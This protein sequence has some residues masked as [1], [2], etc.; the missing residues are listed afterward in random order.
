MSDE[1]TEK[2]EASEPKR[3]R[4]ATPWKRP[5]VR[6]VPASR[7]EIHFGPGTDLTSGAS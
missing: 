6:V 4:V 5:V 7:S 3:E 2:P 1:R